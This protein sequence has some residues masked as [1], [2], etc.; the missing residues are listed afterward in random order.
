MS[1]AFAGV[2]SRVPGV[3]V[4][5]PPSA[6]EAQPGPVE[7]QEYFH[8]AG[9]DSQGR[10]YPSSEIIHISGGERRVMANGEPYTLPLKDVHF[11]NGM[12]RTTD[13]EE[14]RVLD[15]M[16][17]NAGMCMTKSREIYYDHTLT[18][19]QRLQRKVNM[20]NQQNAVIGQQNSEIEQLRREL[21]TE[22]QEKGRLAQMLEEKGKKEK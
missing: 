13:P 9:L 7:Q 19:E 4:V 10:A 11:H 5:D 3:G 20:A 1:G 8:W 14:I 21:A 12:Y 22:K 15:Q 6:A 16:C 2:Q 17:L 18:K